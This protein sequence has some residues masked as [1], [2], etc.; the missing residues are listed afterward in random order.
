[1]TKKDALEAILYIVI[2]I[3]AIIMLIGYEPRNMEYEIP[4][5]F[6]VIESGDEN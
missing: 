2:I 4:K 3:F 6:E 5:A 1:M